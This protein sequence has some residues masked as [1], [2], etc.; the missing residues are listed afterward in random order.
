MLVTER[1]GRLRVVRNGVLDPTPIGPMPQMLATGPRRP[2]GRDAAPALRREPPDL[3]GLL[4]ARRRAGQRHHGGLPRALGRRLHLD[5][6]EGHPGGRRLSRRSGHRTWQRRWKP[7]SRVGQLRVAAGVRYERAAVRHARRPQ[8][9]AQGAGPRL[10]HRQDPSAARRRHR[11][12]RQPVCR[13]AGL[14]ARD[15]HAG[16]P[17]PAGPGLQ[18]HHQRALVHRAGSAG[19]R[20][21]EPHSG[22]QEL[23]VAARVA[24]TQLRRDPRGRRVRRAGARGAGGVLGAGDR[25]LRPH[26]LQRG[27]VSRV[28]GQCVR[29]RHAQQHRAARAARAVQREGAAHR[30]RA[31]ARR[32]EAAH[33]RGGAG[34]RRVPVPADR[35]NVRSRATHRTATAQASEAAPR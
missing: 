20:R 29:G 26:V 30:P 28:E 12:A 16:S 19:R 4:Q 23:R 11:A 1:P 14:Q 3:P 7:G 10:A 8:H 34:S 18:P 9:P 31:H 35:R 6:R 33:P 15:L 21:A 13:Q 5:R 24:G 32:A 2:A 17:Q 22:R 27:Q 25:H